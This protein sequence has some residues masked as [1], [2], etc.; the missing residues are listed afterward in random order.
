MWKAGPETQ[1]FFKF[2]GKPLPAPAEAA[3]TE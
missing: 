3:P 1:G 2:V